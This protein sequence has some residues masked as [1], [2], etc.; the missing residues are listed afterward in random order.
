VRLLL[1]LLV[2]SLLVPEGAARAGGIGW[3]T[4][5]AVAAVLA[6]DRLQLADGREVR[7]AGIR[8]APADSRDAEVAGLAR[9]AREALAAPLEGRLVRL[10]VGDAAIDRYGATA[11]QVERSDG[12]WLQGVLLEAG[13][14]QVQ[15]RPGETLRAAEMLARERTA[16]GAGRGLW[17]VAE[18]A[19]RP[20]DRLADAVGSFRIVRGEVVR[21]APTE[22]YVYLNFGSDWRSDFTVR[23]RRTELDERFARSDIAIER[24]AGRLVEVRGYVLEAGGPLIEV[25]HPEQIE[26]LR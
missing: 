18:F 16:R 12:L 3:S 1:V 24:L 6:G 9:A 21:V 15:T 20:A 26:V 4:P 25:S 13:L 14:A 8:V 17:G 5:V 7:L 2:L 11:A 19:P 23:L 10:A 22:R